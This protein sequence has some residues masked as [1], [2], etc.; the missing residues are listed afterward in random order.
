MHDT[1]DTTQGFLA[2][3]ALIFVVP[4]ALWRLLRNDDWFPLV[5]VQIVTGIVFGPALFGRWFPHAYGF[6]FQPEVT[7]ALNGIG[8]W[9]VMLFIALAGIELDLRSAWVERRAAG[10]TAVLALGVPLVCGCLAAGALLGH[11]GWIG[12]AARSWQF[13]LA[14]GMVCA[15][16]ALPVLILFLDKLALTHQPLGQRI[17]RY[18]S[19]DDVALWGVL[20][21]L[22][23]DWERLA[24]QLGFLLGFMCAAV[25]LRRLMPY[26]ASRERW[27]FVLIWLLLCAFGA[28]WAGLHFIVGA[29]L[30]GAVLDAA[31]F[32]REELAH[33]RR[34]VLLALMPVFFLTTGLRTNWSL[35][36]PAVL[37]VA[38]VLTLAA[39]G[40]KLL[41][42]RLAAHLLGWSRDEAWVVGGLLQ[43]KGLVMILFTSV[44]LD[45]DLISGDTF[46][47]MLLMGLASTIVTVP[48]VAPH[49]T[50]VGAPLS[51]AA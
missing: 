25:L 22:L 27:Y 18:A 19:L 10:L 15:V 24:R 16:T 33:F 20:A 49:L 50:R 51:E 32:G 9:A 7:L 28:E 48:M 47:A 4:Y 5:V 30:A 46:T 45:K 1:I 44:L 3:L 2:A 31:W 38:V 23:M 42:T 26:L 37:L 6:V 8:R 34:Y 12:G 21:L 17:L 43:T 41:G 11:S 40:G 39:I 14:V 35:G 13:V 36:G 29:F